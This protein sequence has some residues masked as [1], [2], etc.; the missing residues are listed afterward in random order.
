MKPPGSAGGEYLS[1]PAT[2]GRWT[3]ALACAVE[4]GVDAVI[5]ADSGLLRHAAREYPALELHLSVQSS[6]TSHEAIAFYHEHF[7]VKRAVLPRVLSLGQVQY[8]V[9]HT[10]VE[11]EV[12][13]FGGL[14]V[15]VEG[16]CAQSAYA[17]GESPN[18]MGACSPAHAMRWQE[19]PSA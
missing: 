7:G 10:P 6:A 17:C 18:T 3:T 12:F 8:V 14:C 9:K 19:T 16:R 13:G 15:M 4:A 2:W 5:A 11:I 1:Q